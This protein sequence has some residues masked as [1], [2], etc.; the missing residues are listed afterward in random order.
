M[1]LASEVD[2]CPTCLA[3]KLRRSSRSTDDSRTAT[4]C[5]Q[6]LSVDFGFIVQQSKN[7]TR[8]KRYLGLKGETCYCLITD[9][10]SGRLYGGTFRSKAPPVEWLNNWLA[11]HAPACPDKCVRFDQGGELAKCAEVHRLFTRAGYDVQ[12]TGSDNSRQNGPGERPHQTIRD[13][14]TA[15]LEGG[16]LSPTFWPFAFHHFIR[17]YNVTPHAASDMSPHQIVTGQ[18]PDLRLLRTFGCR[19]Y[20]RPPGKRPAKLALH[21]D[22]GIFLGYSK[23]M[24]NILYYDLA[25]KN[26]K[27]ASHARFDEGMNDLPSLPPNAE[28]L[29]RAQRGSVS[30]EDIAIP[31]LDLDITQNPFSVLQTEEPPVVCEHPT[32]GFDVSQCDHR[33]WAYVSGVVP[34]ST[35]TWI[36]H[37]R[38]RY[39]GAYI[40][41]IDGQPVFDAADALAAFAHARGRD[42]ATLKLVL[43]PE[44][45]D[46]LKEDHDPIYLGLN[47]I[48]SV[49][50][51]MSE[52]GERDASLLESW[53]DDELQLAIAAVSSTVHSTA[54]ERALGSF[55]RRKLK[56]L[57]TWGQWRASEHKQLDKMATNGMYGE[58]CFA[59]RDAIVLRQHWSY[60]IKANG[61]RYARNCCDGS[62]RAAP[63][64]RAAAQTYASCIEQPCQRVFFALCAGLGLTALSADATNA[65]ANSPPPTVPT[66]VRIDDAYADW[67]KERFGVDL[68]RR[69]VL[70]VLHALQ[71]HP[72]AGALWEKHI[73]QILT[74]LG[75]KSTTHEKNI[76]SG[77]IDG[78]LVLICRQVDDLAIAS[79]DPS[80]AQS[81]IDRLADQVALTSDGILTSFNGIDVSQTRNYVRISC[82]S[83]IRRMLESHGWSQGHPNEGHH[84][85]LE[86]M[87][88]HLAAQVDRESGPPEHTPEARQ[89]ETTHKFNYRSVLGELMCA[90]VVGRLDIGY[91]IT[92]LARHAVQPADIHYAALKRVA[93]YLRITA[94]W[95]IIY[96]RPRPVEH[97]PVGDV[98][99]ISADPALPSFPTPVDPL[100]LVGYVDAA[101]GTDSTTR[102]SVTGYAFLLCGGAVAHRS[103][104]QS[105]VA[106]S[107]TESEFI[108]AVQ[109]AKTAKYLRSVLFELGFPQEGPTRLYEDNQAA[110]LMTNANKPTP[111]SRHIDIQHFALQEWK[112]HGD[113]IME[114]VPG[115][116]NLADALTKALGW[117]LHHRHSRRMMGHF[118][119]PAA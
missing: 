3:A 37:A 117:V 2:K 64:L 101:Y 13:G 63:E 23:T 84:Q 98:T 75:F 77:H 34:S 26:I 82:A 14:I 91:A 103:K 56:N 33:H 106:T 81:V 60:T 73:N 9:H 45:A 61:D 95:G 58:P 19:V 6:G 16:D 85:K 76:Y 96:W 46:P 92:R 97:L 43:A 108:A 115:I 107:S 20:A 51:I 28:Y 44:R 10:K 62:R 109:A 27:L 70:P 72:E 50:A 53:S 36:R 55:T 24:K 67:Y 25:T 39:L 111:R 41:S 87:P 49:T 68:D 5:N 22:K 80:V 57:D 8:C 4:V 42:L 105:I 88:D 79:A 21:C 54:A 18:L 17:L 116:L 90:Y 89:L 48:W 38:R 93:K 102:R 30:A 66:F 7:E 86:P 35:A 104:L 112:Q 40:V 59:P 29:T 94:D 100:R 119:A 15:L 1:N 74:K 12:F 83:Y 113:V 71:G 52:M 69:M 118:A 47:I 11:K 65:Y 78:A 114:H 110:I 32:F 99:P 31:A